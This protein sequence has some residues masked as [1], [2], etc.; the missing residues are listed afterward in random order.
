MLNNLRNTN[1]LNIKNLLKL[2]LI[3]LAAH[4][5][6]HKK[7]LSTP[8]LWIL[9]YHRVLP[10]NDPRFQL[11][12]P[13]MVVTP[14]TFEMHI[15]EAKKYFQIMAL[16]DW[17][18]KYQAGEPL[19]PKAC[20]ITF[21]DG[22]QD[23]Y[24]F[25]LPVL[26][27]HQVPATL[28]AVAEKIGTDFQFWPNTILWLLFN[29]GAEALSQHPIL[30]QGFPHQT[31]INREIAASYILQLKQLSDKSIF[32]ALTEIEAST[33][34]ISAMPRAL[35][36]WDE[37]RSMQASGLVDIGSHTCNHKRLT[38]HLG[39]DELQHEICKSK[40]ILEAELNQTIDLFCFP[41]GD[42]N[43]AALDLVKTTYVAAVTTQKGIVSNNNF[44]LHEL[45]RIGLHEQVS[46][47]PG[48]FGARLSGLM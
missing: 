35:M 31:P 8:H 21:D 41:N 48:N 44:S 30:G 3:H 33:N 23:N 38:Q 12:E 37:L 28:F 40:D 26:Q 9:M 20:V 7:S 10:K 24:E 47:T 42:Y 16:K 6:S 18:Q 5:G 25:A 17:V 11:E 22:W 15:Q 27:R 46:Q 36:N 32:T 45:K 39:Q 1:M 2:P 43:Q 29:G 4:F 14:E 13:G 34:L 19:P